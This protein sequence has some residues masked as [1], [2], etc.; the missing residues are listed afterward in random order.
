MLSTDNEPIIVVCASDNNYA[1]PLAVTVRSALVNLKSQRKILL[2]I[3]D[4]GIKN[5]NKQKILQSISIDNCE[6]KFIPKPDSWLDLMKF[7]NLEKKHWLSVSGAAFYRLMIAELLPKQFDKAIYLDCDLVVRGNLEELW[8]NDLA[9]NYI[10]AVQNLRIPYV[11]SPWGL[12]NYKELGISPDT[13]YFN[14]GVLV[15]NLKKWR[16]DKM[17]IKAI[18]YLNKNKEYIR[19]HDQD[20]LNALFANQWGELDPR[21]NVPPYITDIYPSWADSLFSE[22]VYNVLISEPYIIHYL[23]DKKPWTSRHTPLKDYFFHYL[24]MTA[25]SGWRLTTWRRLKLKLIHKFEN[26]MSK[27]TNQGDI[28]AF[29]K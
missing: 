22:E 28:F 23:T 4:G 13:K 11:S 1:M 3:I 14:S 19:M 8:T 2:F 25:W 5:H 18:E 15:I 17:T 6:I 9:D 7:D 10:L 26:L 21:W 29:F 24:D 27:I 20:G 16:D 12:L